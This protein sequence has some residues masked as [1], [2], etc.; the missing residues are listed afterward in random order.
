MWK[1]VGVLT[2]LLAARAARKALNSGWRRTT[3][4]DPPVNPA[5]PRTTWG[6][7]LGWAAAS[8]IAIGVSR[9][10]ADRVAAAGWQKA[11]GSLPPG[12]EEVD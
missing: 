9:M 3:G 11:T 12:L 2:G 4:G 8:G 5:S 1:L 10:V 7:A 6:E